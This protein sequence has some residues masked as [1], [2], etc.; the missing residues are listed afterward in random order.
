MLFNPR[1]SLI[2][3]TT[4]VVLLLLLPPSLSRWTNALADPAKT[5]VYPISAPM[6][7]LLAFNPLSAVSTDA[8]AARQA[9]NQRDQL[10]TQKLALERDIERLQQMVKDLQGGIELNPGLVVRQ[11][12]APVLGRT[13][14]L[15]SEIITVR[16][17]RRQGVEPGSVVVSRGVNLIGRVSSRE[18]AVR[19]RTCEVVAITDKSAGL[20]NGV[21][22]LDALTP[23][24]TCQLVER[25]RSV[26]PSGSTLVM[27]VADELTGADAM[28]GSFRQI[29]VGMTV[30]LQDDNWPRTAQRFV[31]GRIV[32]MESKPDNPLRRLIVVK[33]EIDPTRVSEVTIRWLT[34][35]EEPRAVSP[36]TG[37]RP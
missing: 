3:A 26:G 6:H 33:P 2:M 23:G 17:G 11:F 19:D 36:T 15:S 12:T 18:G 22:M 14:D 35:A 9:I 30:R 4:L 21:V 37:G 7:H 20:I 25:R 34:E 16:A 24:P 8:E 31:I 13:S 5:L 27:L 28:T 32:S 10:L 1:A 29:E